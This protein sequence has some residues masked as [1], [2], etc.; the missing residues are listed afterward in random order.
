MVAM[1]RLEVP[2]RQESLSQEMQAGKA[3]LANSTIFLIGASTNTPCL[4]VIRRICE[5][6]GV[7]RKEVD[8]DEAA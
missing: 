3:A 5:A 7:S 2:R 6:L 4:G 8:E 1:A